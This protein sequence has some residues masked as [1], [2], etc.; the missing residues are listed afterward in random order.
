MFN[1]IFFL[2]FFSLTLSSSNIDRL[3]ENTWNYNNKGSDWTGTCSTGALQ[4]PIDVDPIL[5]PCDNSM[6]LGLSF[7][8]GEQTFT[9]IDTE[10]AFKGITSASSLYATDINGLLT[11]YRSLYFELHAP[12]EHKLE[13]EEFDLE[14]IIYYYITDFFAEKGLTNKTYAA[15]SILFEVDDGAEV[16]SFIDQLDLSTVTSNGNTISLDLKAE[17]YDK[18][19][20]PIVYYTYQGS[21]VTPPCEEIVNWYIIEKPQKIKKSQLESISDRYERNSSF[22]NGNGNSRDLRPVHDREIK[23][24]GVECEEQFVY[25]FVF[26]VMF[27][28]ISYFVFKLIQ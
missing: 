22:A 14:L 5:S 21:F 8:E 13:G 19:T 23:K 25:F 20:S 10:N 27:I 15:V 28:L 3:L 11:G 16:N 1:I 6:V 2:T 18:L 7:E 4:S 12:A 9:L 17:L 24:G 26:V